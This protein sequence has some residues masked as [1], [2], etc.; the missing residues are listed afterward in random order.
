MSFKP[1]NAFAFVRAQPS[2]FHH[3]QMLEL[4]EDILDIIY[5]FIQSETYFLLHYDARKAIV[6]RNVN[7]APLPS[8]M[9][10]GIFREMLSEQNIHETDFRFITENDRWLTT[11]YEHKMFSK[12]NCKVFSLFYP[13]KIKEQI[14]WISAQGNCLFDMEFYWPKEYFEEYLPEILNKN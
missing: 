4:C 8:H 14:V 1:L 2:G 7:R 3:Y 10:S 13:P 6:R 12:H 5:S 9:V 11:Q